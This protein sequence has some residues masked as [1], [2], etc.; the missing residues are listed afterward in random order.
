MNICIPIEEDKGLLSEICL[1]F[2][3]A[4]RFIIVDTQTLKY[5]VVP[6]ENPSEESVPK[7][8]LSGDR[9]DSVMVGGI[10][11][12]SLSDFRE[13][14]IEVV[15]TKEDTVE[16]IVASFK[17]GDVNPVSLDHTCRFQHSGRGFRGPG[18]CGGQGECL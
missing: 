1:R 7:E 3:S 13:A 5:R 14:G 12:R 6:S 9:I 18:G 15:S 11:I 2:G 17:E 8:I 16:Q 10:G 4:P